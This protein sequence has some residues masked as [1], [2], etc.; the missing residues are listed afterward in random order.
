MLRLGKLFEEN[1][2]YHI[3]FDFYIPVDI[4]IDYSET[5]F[6]EIIEYGDSKRSILEIYKQRYSGKITAITLVNVAKSKISDSQD[7]R[8]VTRIRK[9]PGM[10][11]IFEEDSVNMIDENWKHISCNQDFEVILNE[12]Y[13]MISFCGMTLDRVMTQMNDL[14][15]IFDQNLNLSKI[16]IKIFDKKSY[17]LLKEALH[18]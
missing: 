4:R 13:L 17:D 10:K 1:Y 18:L 9:V 3:D 8:N 7:F 2:S 15:F 16:V 14:E 6:E 5:D 12:N 11:K